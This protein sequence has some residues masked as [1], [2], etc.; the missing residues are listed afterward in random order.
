MRVGLL[1]V[2]MDITNKASPLSLST[3]CGLSAADN[4]RRGKSRRDLYPMRL[5]LNYTERYISGLQLYGTV[6]SSS[7]GHAADVPVTWVVTTLCRNSDV[8]E[9]DSGLRFEAVVQPFRSLRIP[10][11]LLVRRARPILP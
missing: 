5:P 7:K 6:R 10:P 1:V 2:C 3:S 9:T 11:V 4:I 8:I